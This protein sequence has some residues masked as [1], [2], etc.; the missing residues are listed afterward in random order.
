M[1]PKQAVQLD[2]C[3]VHFQF[4]FCDAQLQQCPGFINNAPR[5][6]YQANAKLLLH[7]HMYMDN[8]LE[9]DVNEHLVNCG[10]CQEHMMLSSMEAEQ[11]NKCHAWEAS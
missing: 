9:Q 3:S 2:N 7:L 4:W 6:G 5:G 1:K 8:K 11:D 10:D